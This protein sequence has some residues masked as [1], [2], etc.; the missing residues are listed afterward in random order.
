MSLGSYSVMGLWSAIRPYNQP[1]PGSAQVVPDSVTNVMGTQE[2]DQEDQASCD[3]TRDDKM[4][5][6]QCGLRHTSSS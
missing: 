3:E 6:E 4:I 5:F 2:D 1:L